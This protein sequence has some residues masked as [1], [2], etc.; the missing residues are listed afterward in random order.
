M[1]GLHICSFTTIPKAEIVLN[2]KPYYFEF[3]KRFGPLRL[4]Q[5]NYELA[6]NQ[7]FPKDFWHEFEE[8]HKKYLRGKDSK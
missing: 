2:G 8:W 3:S 5:R 6:K 1:K 7:E 4:D